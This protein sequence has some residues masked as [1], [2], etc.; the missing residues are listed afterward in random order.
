MCMN[1]PCEHYP[2][3]QM[4]VAVTFCHRDQRW[5]GT[6]AVMTTLADG[7]IVQ[8]GAASREFGPFDSYIEVGHWMASHARGLRLMAERTSFE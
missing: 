2:A 4:N 8:Q 5:H 3:S 1:E 7:E 6:V